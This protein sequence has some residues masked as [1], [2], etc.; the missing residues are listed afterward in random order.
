MDKSKQSLQ[1]AKLD[2]LSDGEFSRIGITAMASSRYRL[3]MKIL[4]FALFVIVICVW[5]HSYFYIQE[6]NPPNLHRIFLGIHFF[7]VLPFAISRMQNLASGW[8]FSRALMRQVRTEGEASD[9]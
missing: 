3:E 8:I 9:F 4:F 5:A 2:S 6:L 1:R 7:I